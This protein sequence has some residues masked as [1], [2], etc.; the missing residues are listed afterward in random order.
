MEPRTRNVLT[1]AVVAGV[2]LISGTLSAGEP[3]QGRDTVTITVR[4]DDR[5]RVPNPLLKHA[6][7]RASAVFGMR[8]VELRW[9]DARDPRYLE[10]SARAI[11]LIIAE[12][13]EPMKEHEGVDVDIMGQAVPWVGRAYVYYGRILRNVTP[14]RDIITTLGDVMAHELGHLMLP[15]GHSPHGIMQPTVNLASRRLVTFTKEQA[16]AIRQ[17]LLETNS[18]PNEW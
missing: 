13:P 17:R 9:V 7:L 18:F 11:T 6:E 12:T 4:V 15:R 5:A 2:L 10:L 3:H 14:T 8:D 16:S 1:P